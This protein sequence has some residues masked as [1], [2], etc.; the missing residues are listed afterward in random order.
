MLA[1]AR[2]F[3]PCYFR[4]T[5]AGGA[6]GWAFVWLRVW[7]IVPIFRCNPSGHWQTCRAYCVVLFPAKL[8]SCVGNSFLNRQLRLCMR[9]L[10]FVVGDACE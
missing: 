6:F 7:W 4:G 8:R 10:A 5:V 9:S 1:Q 2:V 3:R